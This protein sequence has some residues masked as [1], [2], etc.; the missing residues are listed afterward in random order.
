MSANASEESVMSLS[1]ILNQ[2]APGTPTRDL[3]P[4]EVF[5]PGDD[6][7]KIRALIRLILPSAP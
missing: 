7:E 2:S 4:D 3:S 5:P 6:E 1:E